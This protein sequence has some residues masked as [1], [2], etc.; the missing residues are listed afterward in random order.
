MEY[1]LGEASSIK[2][3]LIIGSGFAGICAAIRLK[4]LHFDDFIILERESE[5]GGT[6]RDNHYPGCACDVESHLYCFSFEPNPNWSRQFS[7]QIEILDYIRH[8]AVKYNILKHMRFN[9]NV[10]ESFFDEERTIWRV[11]IENGVTLTASIVISAMG[12][13]SNPLIPEVK[14]LNLFKGIKFHS[15]SWKSA[16]DPTNMRIAV[17]GNGA[18]AVQFVPH[19]VKK[20]ARVDLYQRSASW[21]LPKFDWQRSLLEKEACKVIPFFQSFTRLFIYWS[22]E[23]RCVGFLFPSLMFIVELLC[24]LFLFLSIRNPEKRR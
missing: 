12:S 14:G 8:C 2:N 3:V 24:K 4:M 23:F 11:R 6:W 1:S 21:V 13:L 16:F 9:S 7:P 15:A 18:S 10:V 19:L 5:L 17:V 20:A 22:L